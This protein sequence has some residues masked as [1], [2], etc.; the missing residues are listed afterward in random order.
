MS[1]VCWVAML[2]EKAQNLFIFF[3]FSREGEPRMAK[4]VRESVRTMS[5][6]LTKKLK[7]KRET[8]QRRASKQLIREFK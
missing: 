8:K 2:L 4:E 6:G 1:F 7:K 5:R 3:R